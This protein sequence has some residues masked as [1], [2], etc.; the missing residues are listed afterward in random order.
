MLRYFTTLFTWIITLTV[1]AVAGGFAILY[2]Y[3]AGLPDYQQLAKYEPPVLTRFY[4]NDGRMFAEYAAEKRLFVPLSAMPKSLSNAFI[5]AEDKHFYEHIGIDFGSIVAAV[6][7]NIS[8]IQ[9]SKRPIGA[10]TITQQVARNFLLTDISTQV[11]YAR[12]IK[13]AILAFR[14]EQTFTKD[15][16]LELYLNEI[17]L[18]NGAYGVAA[19]ALSYFN[20]S[21]NELTI[22]EAAFL[23]A[24]PKAPSRYHPVKAPI[25]A[26]TRRDYVLRR[27]FEDGFIDHNSLITA[28]SKPIEAQECNP[29]DT[30]HAEYF[31]E[32]VRRELHDKYGEKALY[33]DGMAVRTTLDRE[34]QAV[35]TEALREGLLDYDRRHGW[36]GPINHIN[37]DAVQKS[38]INGESN[39]LKLLSTQS[40]P[41]G[42]GSWRGAVVLDLTPNHAIIGLEDSGIGLVP[43]TEL[44][45][46]RTYISTGERGPVIQKPGDVLKVGDIILV[47][48]LTVIKLNESLR[49]PELPVQDKPAFQLCQIPLVSGALLAMDI[50]TGRV[51]AMQGGFDFKMSQF[52]RATQALRQTG[53]AFKT[54]VY[55]TGFERGLT[56]ATRIDDAPFSID[57]GPGQGVWAPHNYEEQFWGLLTLS[58][59]FEL[60]RNTVTVR[61]THDYIGMKNVVATA[62]RFGIIDNMPV[63]LAMVLG[64]GETTLLKMV[65]G[66]ATIA[67]GGLSI[68]PTFIDR[69]QDRHGKNVLNTTAFQYQGDITSLEAVPT[70]YDNREAVTDPA[71]AFQVIQ[72]LEGVAARGT[73]KILQQLNRPIAGKS[74]TTN[75]FKDAWFIGFTP[76]LI[77]GVYIGFDHPHFMGMHE[78][79]GRLAAPIVKNFFQKALVNVPA[80]PFPI[81]AGI[82]LVRINAYTGKPAS[83]GEKDAIWQGFKPGTEIKKTLSEDG[84]IIED[85]SM[86]Q[87]PE[88][89]DTIMQSP[90]TVNE[91]LGGLY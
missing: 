6:L 87:E 39:W 74:G 24:L 22:G 59:A 35:A 76:D 43:I 17:Y 7:T 62:K 84:A 12:K 65:R 8:R 36:R 38:Y 89:I 81:P 75:D 9:E 37:L 67:N 57:L 20:K 86:N 19:A 11:S 26:R 61:M 32:E 79:G 91:G 58:R 64:A 42:K 53:S 13:E 73:G 15:H 63:Q 1:I 21:L 72:L 23:A 82:K 80:K 30:I 52:N 85:E 33:K 83:P 55:L 54:F 90:P 45:W 44:K 27:M 78:S 5:A 28:L 4:A 47:T 46:A 66:T 70:V 41:L 51:L 68:N 29:N 77:V 60:S 56:P 14:I 25:L 71:T 18:G 69:V 88:K 2:Y 34:L 31:A 48:P 49:R 40:W 10:S 50:H 16:I 3:G